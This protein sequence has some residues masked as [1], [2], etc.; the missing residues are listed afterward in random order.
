MDLEFTK[1]SLGKRFWLFLSL[2]IALLGFMSCIF[3]LTPQMM[4]PVSAQTRGYECVVL[5]HGLGRTSSSMRSMESVLNDSGYRTVNRDYPSTSL[6][7]EEIAEKFLPQFIAEC[8]GQ[9]GRIHFVTHS[10][11]GIILRYYLQLNGL[12]PGSRM[13]MLSP[14]NKGSELADQLKDQFWYQWLMG[15]SGQ[16]LTTDPHSLPNKLEPVSIE[17]GVIAGRK[18]LEPWFSWLIPGEDDG[19]VSV[20]HARLSEM[21]DFLVVDHGHTFIMN[22]GEVKKQVIHFLANGFFKKSLDP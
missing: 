4:T 18:T 20:D 19:K 15:P 13:V 22:S 14:P 5:L 12:P 3:T 16:Q 11:G 1:Q 8:G 17:V 6:P 10:L 7:I 9:A 21:T 2:P